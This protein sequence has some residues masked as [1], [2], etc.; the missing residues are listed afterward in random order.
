MHVATYPWDVSRSN[1]MSSQLYFI[2]MQDKNE[3]AALKNLTPKQ[4]YVVV[5]VLSS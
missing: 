2:P 3:S 4:F 5:V 1:Y